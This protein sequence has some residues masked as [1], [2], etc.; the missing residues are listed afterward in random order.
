M[1]GLPPAAPLQMLPG[2]YPPPAPTVA[3]TAQ[4]AT[5]AARFNLAA[6]NVYRALVV[7]EAKKAGAAGL[8]LSNVD[9]QSIT[10]GPA[11]LAVRTRVVLKA[12]QEAAA[13]ALATRLAVSPDA[14]WLDSTWPG[15]SVSDVSG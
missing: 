15:S 1:A 12:D 14:A 2:A 3:F 4:I 11:A 10:P 9:L 8:S 6:Q 7:M 5:T 13:Q